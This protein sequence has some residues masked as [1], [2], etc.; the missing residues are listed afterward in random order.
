MHFC[1]AEVER[2]HRALPA[3]AADAR[4]GRIRAE[5]TVSAPDHEMV[6]ILKQTVRDLGRKE[7]VRAVSLGA[8]D[9]KHWRQH[10]VPSYVYGCTTDQHGQARR[11]G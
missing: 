10:G 2:D 7:P 9:C 11:V 5:P 6:G 4:S 8:T 3:G 1:C